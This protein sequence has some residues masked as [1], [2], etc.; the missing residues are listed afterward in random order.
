MS[1]SVRENAALS[2]LPRF[3]RFG[4]VRRRVESAARRG[5]A[6]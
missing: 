1:L 6:R 3:A 4:V 2:A 5:A